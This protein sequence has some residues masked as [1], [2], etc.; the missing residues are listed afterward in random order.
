MGSIFCLED[1]ELR[2][3]EKPKKRE[4][5]VLTLSKNKGRIESEEK[6]KALGGDRVILLGATG[7]KYLAIINGEA[8]CYYYDLEVALY[9]Y[10]QYKLQHFNINIWYIESAKTVYTFQINNL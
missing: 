8:D 4:E 5:F 10:S 9:F 6:V 1:G 2:E 3:V 7:N